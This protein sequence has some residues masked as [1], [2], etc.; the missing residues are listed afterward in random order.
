ML[1]SRYRNGKLRN[2]GSNRAD[3]STETGSGVCLASP[4]D[5]HPSLR[6]ISRVLA[7]QKQLSQKR[8]MKGRHI[9]LEGVERVDVHCNP[10]LILKVETHGQG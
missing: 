9:Y 7:L 3:A 1:P 6:L 4:V 10:R 5:L 2:H 8:L